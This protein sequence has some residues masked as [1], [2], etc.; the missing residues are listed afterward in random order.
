MSDSETTVTDTAP[1]PPP[2]P[3]VEA[4]ARVQ[5]WKPL[6]EFRGDPAKWVPADTFMARGIETPA[7]LAERNN[8]LAGRLSRTEGML[9]R[10][11]QEL[12]GKLDEA[13]GTVAT[14]TQMMR[15]SEQRAYER[16]KRDIKA[17]MEKAVASGD[18]AAFSRL[19]AQRDE[20]ERTKPAD[21]PLVV[22]RRETTT[23]PPPGP[24]EDHRDA[25]HPAVKRFL[26]T[27]RWYDPSQQ[28]TDRDQIMMAYTD[29]VLAGLRATQPNVPLAEHIEHVEQELR[30][31]FPDKFR[32]TVANGH[33]PDDRRQEPA[34]VT[35]SSASVP[36]RRT[37]QRF[38]FD[39]MPKESKDAYAKYEGQLKSYNETRGIKHEP[40]SKDQ[41]ASDY[42]S[43]FQ[44]DGA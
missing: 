11:R 19:D 14:M 28:R 32:A 39:T 36:T 5:G 16:A 41:W 15:T 2:D 3:A 27:H 29:T 4:V 13:L 26:E 23:T 12:G 9:D 31:R 21:T 44:D 35:P 33:D 34:S 40:L 6:A 25:N 42:W 30:A 7:I 10:T 37:A 8:V 18:A 22:P 38:T 24:V 20:L 1:P 17:E 43:Q